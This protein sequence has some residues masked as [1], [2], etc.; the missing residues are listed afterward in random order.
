MARR[1][2]DPRALVTAFHARHWTLTVPEQGARAARAY[3]GDALRGGAGRRSGDGV[4][5]AQRALPLL[6]R[7]RRR[8]CPRSGDRSDGRDR[9]PDPADRL[10]LAHGLPAGRPRDP[11]RTLRGRGGVGGD[12]APAR[13]APSERVPDVRLPV[14]AAVCDSLGA[15]TAGASSGRRS[16]LTASCIRGYPAGET[17]WPPPSSATGGLRVRRWSGTHAADFADVPRDGLWLLHLCTLAEGCVLIGD[18]QRG[19]LLYELLLPHGDRNAVSYTQQPFGPVALRLGMLASMSEQWED[20]ERHFAS[21]RERCEALGARGILPRVLYEHARM[22]LAR[23]GAGDEQ[24]GG[25]SARRGRGVE[26]GAR[27]FRAARTHRGAPRDAAPASVT[28]ARPVF[29]RE[30]EIWTIGYEGETFRLRDVKGLRYIAF[31]LGSPGRETHAVELAQAVEGVPEHARADGPPGPAAR[32]TGEGRVSPAPGGARRGARGGARLGRSRA[33]RAR[34]SGD[35]RAHRAAGAGDRPRRARPR[36]RLTRGAGPRQRDE[37]DQVGDQDD[38]APLPRS[39]RA[40]HRFDPHRPVLLVRTAGR[41]AAALATLNRRVRLAAQLFHALL[42]PRVPSANE[43]GDSM[44]SDDDTCRSRPR[45][46][47]RLRGPADRAART[48]TTTQARAVYNAMIDKRPALIARCASLGDVSQ[49]DRLR[50]AT[51]TCCSRSAAAATT[52]PGWARATTE[53]SSTSRC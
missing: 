27:P 13:P 41:A 7:T 15:G 26:R 28:A 42:R 46:A 45:R 5:G 49:G 35:R 17:L 19:R 39:R 24:A 22:L 2:D 38:R 25:S 29:R 40:P 36:R 47:R 44:S 12:R 21:A 34:G 51:T 23:G 31:L 32:R 30:G 9:R 20:A 8:P 52:A 10:S 33:G 16:A 3:G 11:R 14:R 6:P 1:I 50:A 37:G 53:W 48:P 43:E 4:P 18:E